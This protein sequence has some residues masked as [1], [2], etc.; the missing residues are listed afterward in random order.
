[1]LDTDSDVAEFRPLL[2]SEEELTLSVHIAT[3]KSPTPLPWIQ[4]STIVLVDLC[5]ALSA[6]SMSPY[7]TE[8]RLFAAGFMAFTILSSLSA[9]WI[10]SREI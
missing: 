3:E 1:M 10:S 8:V 4:F 9:D 7:I 6:S 2:G 5:A